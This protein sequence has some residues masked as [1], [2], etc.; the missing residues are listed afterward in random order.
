MATLR[1]NAAHLSSKSRVAGAAVGARRAVVAAPV[2]APLVVEAAHKKG[3]G[4]S[5]NGRDS[6]A[7]RL[8]C[9]VYG[10][11][12]V[13]P[14]NVIYRQRG[15]E[16]HAGPGTKLGHDYTVFA[17][18]EGVVKFEKTKRKKRILVVPAPPPPPVGAS[19]QAK[20]DKYTPRA[21]LRA[22]EA[23]E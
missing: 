6:N 13:T 14:G 19:R 3:V 2:A 4:S 10:G 20:Y 15:S 5:K 17:M 23:Q 1:M 21:E 8:G 12:P 11:Q 7:K 18:T 22:A 16:W 9:K